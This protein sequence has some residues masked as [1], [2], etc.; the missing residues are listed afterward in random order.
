MRIVTRLNRVAQQLVLAADLSTSAC[1]VDLKIDPSQQ[2][3][4]YGVHFGYNFPIDADKGN[5]RAGYCVGYI[6]PTFD[7]QTITSFS[8]QVFNES[9]GEI[10]WFDYAR[11]PNEVGNFDDMSTPMIITG[12]NRLTFILSPPAILGGAAGSIQM[13]L[14]VRG[15]IT[16]T[17]SQDKPR[18]GDWNLR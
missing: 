9:L 16:Q 1:I 17:P 12:D 3:Q 15:E 13:A 11:L 14:E 18:L 10:V 7:P 2:F 5:S 8:S 6:N 4:I